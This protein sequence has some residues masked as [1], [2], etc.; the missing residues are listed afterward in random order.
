MKCLTCVAYDKEYTRQGLVEY[1]DRNLFELSPA[2]RLKFALKYGGLVLL[3]LVM[4][5]FAFAL[6]RDIG[7]VDVNIPM[8]LN[9][10]GFGDW[11][12]YFTYMRIPF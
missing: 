5:S 1:K 7:I 4:F 9:A 10:N 8:R 12:D 11:R 3:A 6:A 2:E